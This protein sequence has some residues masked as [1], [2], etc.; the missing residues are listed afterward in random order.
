MIG[1]GDAQLARSRGAADGEEQQQ[2]AHSENPENRISENQ[3][4]NNSLFP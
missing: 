2:A 1:G 4:K 3:I